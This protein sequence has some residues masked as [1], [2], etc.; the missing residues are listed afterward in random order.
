[1]SGVRAGRVVKPSLTRGHR[2]KKGPVLRMMAI[3]QDGNNSQEEVP[4]EFLDTGRTGRRNALPDILSADSE[5][6]TADLPTRLQ[7]LATNVY[8]ASAVPHDNSSKSSCA[9]MNSVLQDFV[10]SGCHRRRNAVADITHNSCHYHGKYPEMSCKCCK[11]V[12][13]MTDPV[14]EEYEEHQSNLHNL[15]LF[16]FNR[17]AGLCLPC[18]RGSGRSEPGSPQAGPSNA[19]AQKGEDAKDKKNKAS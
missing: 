3:M 2:A 5:V 4:K 8:T 9:C 1:M 19:E 14:I 12:M 7:M 16:T 6:T 10:A 18:F 17:N 13:T 11:D 15:K